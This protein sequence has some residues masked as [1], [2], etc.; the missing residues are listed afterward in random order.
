ALADKVLVPVLGDAYGVVLERGELELR[1][2]RELGSFAVFFHEHRFPL[3]PRTYPRVL[4]RV[5]AH[6]S[7]AALE[8]L[9]RAFGAPP[10][11]R[12]PTQEQIAERDRQKEI[13]KRALASLCA[14]DASVTQ[15]IDAA[16]RSFAGD[17][18]EP[19]SFDA[20]HE[21]LELQAYRL[22]Y[23]RVASDEINYRRFFDVNSLGALRVENEAVFE[24]THRLVLE[25][26]GQGKI[27]GLRV[28][29]PDGLYNPAQYF[30]PL[31]HP[32]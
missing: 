23:W 4:D 3:D 22:A 2:E 16:L 24:A 6:V 18:A 5:L 28:D 30:K 10:Q 1:F 15:A 19:A 26:V 27:D 32:L 7:S 13:H 31:P 12:E 17:P 29:H 9:K 25:L 8:N 20:L 21:L 11:R 14:A